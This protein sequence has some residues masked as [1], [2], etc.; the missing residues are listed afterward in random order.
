MKLAA[1]GYLALFLSAQSA[2]AVSSDIGVSHISE[3]VGMW[4]VSFDWSE[5]EEYTKSI[6]QSSSEASGIKTTIDTLSLKSR[7]DPGRTMRISILKYSTVD[8]TLANIANLQA[9][10]NDT[11]KL[12]GACNNVVCSIRNMDGRDGAFAC[13]IECARGN[14][15]YVAVYPIDYYLDKSIHA[16]M[17]KALGIMSSSYDSESTE[18]ML[19]SIHIEHIG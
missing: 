10:A 4:S 11:A 2:I 16:L 7:V 14:A 3:Q 5:M 6:S 9:R 18:R 8:S 15:F 13:G 12:A 1:I 19:K 17:S